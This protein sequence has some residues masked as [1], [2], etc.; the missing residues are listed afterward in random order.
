[1]PITNA[2]WTWN[3]TQNEQWHKQTQHIVF[4]CNV[5]FACLASSDF[6]CFSS[7]VFSCLY[8][9]V[10]AVFRLRCLN[11]DVVYIWIL[12]STPS[13]VVYIRGSRCINISLLLLIIV[14]YSIVI[15]DNSHTI[16]FIIKTSSGLT[17]MNTCCQAAVHP[18]H[19]I[20]A[21]PL[22]YTCHNASYNTKVKSSLWFDS[23]MFWNSESAGK[24]GVPWKAHAS[25]QQTKQTSKTGS[26]LQCIH[27][28][29][30]W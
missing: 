19:Y 15:I 27:I 26:H 10:I 16:W 29:I 24:E 18:T 13:S 17:A 6:N 25:S 8:S 3:Q 22:Q 28:N 11:V 14:K 1:M 9:F 5:S 12:Y 30:A 23:Y 7:C 21:T 4:V 20:S 2:F